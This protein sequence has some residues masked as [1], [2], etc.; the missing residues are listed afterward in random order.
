MGSMMKKITSFL[1]AVFAT[2]SFYIFPISAKFIRANDAKY[3]DEALA[4]EIEEMVGQKQ[5]FL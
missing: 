3:T 2:T 5:I 1:L 4:D